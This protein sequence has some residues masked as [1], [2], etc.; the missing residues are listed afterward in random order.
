MSKEK[1][2]YLSHDISVSHV[3]MVLLEFT[4]TTTTTLDQGQNDIDVI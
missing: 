4:T 3:E 1:K 2:S